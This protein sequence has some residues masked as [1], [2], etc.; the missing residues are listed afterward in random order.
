MLRRRVPLTSR[1]AAL[2]KNLEG[3]ATMSIP[4]DTKHSGQIPMLLK[5]LLERP[6]YKLSLKPHCIVSS[7]VLAVPTP[8]VRSFPHLAPAT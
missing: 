2:G 7:N 5:T 4:S 1:V 3:E 8:V 6:F